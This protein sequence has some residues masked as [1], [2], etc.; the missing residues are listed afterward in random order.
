MIGYFIHSKTIFIA[1][2]SIIKILRDGDDHNIKAGIYFLKSLVNKR[3][4]ILLKEYI[5]FI[6]E[7]AKRYD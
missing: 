3:N 5:Y 1:F 7:L 4:F 2:F 6:I